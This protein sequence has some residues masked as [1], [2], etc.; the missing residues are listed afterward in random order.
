MMQHLRGA[1][2]AIRHPLR[3]LDSNAYVSVGIQ[4]S[5]HVAS[6]LQN[7]TEI[8]YWYQSATDVHNVC[9]AHN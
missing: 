7:L 2:L 1:P 3:S 8:S 6:I 9:A 4:N 5:L